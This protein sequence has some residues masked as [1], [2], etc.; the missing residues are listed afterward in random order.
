MSIVM[1]RALHK[2]E[3]F[4]MLHLFLMMLELQGGYKVSDVSQ[5]L[6]EI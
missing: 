6:F 2:Y 1:E 3:E 5:Y 4:E